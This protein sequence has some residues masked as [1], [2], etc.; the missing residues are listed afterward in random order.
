MNFKLALLILVFLSC[1]SG[2]TDVVLNFPEIKLIPLR[3][4]S[5]EFQS[6]NVS[7]LEKTTQDEIAIRVAWEPL[8]NPTSYQAINIYRIFDNGSRTLAAR[9]LL[10]ANNSLLI[11]SIVSD[12]SL[13]K[14]DENLQFGMTLESKSGGESSLGNSNI[15]SIYL[16]YGEPDEVSILNDTTEKIELFWKTGLNGDNNSVFNINSVRGHL[17]DSISLN[18]EKEDGFGKME[19]I[20]TLHGSST[21]MGLESG[22]QFS[23]RTYS[24]SVPDLKQKFLDGSITRLGDYDKTLF[25]PTSINA[26]FENTGNYRIYF[27]L[28]KYDTEQSGNF[29]SH[30]TNL[31]SFSLN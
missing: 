26:L 3:A 2:S 13:L 10:I 27:Y 23:N 5:M 29:F 1:E 15:I 28:Y 9:S 14:Y 24:L 6:S 12:S 20:L 8:A 7:Y 16:S 18:I 22:N 30:K 19:K 31:Y 4:K 21:S 25:S 11:E 17:L